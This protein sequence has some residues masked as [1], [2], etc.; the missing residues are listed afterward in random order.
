MHLHADLPLR[1]RPSPPPHPIPPLACVRVCAQPEKLGTADLVE[2]VE[3]GKG[4]VVKVTGIV[5]KGRTTSVLLR[6]SNK[7]VMEESER[8]LHDALCVIRCLVNKRFLITGGASPET[9]V[10]YQLSTWAKSLLG[11]ESYCVKAFAEALEV[12]PYTLAENAGLNPIQMVTELRNRHARGERTAGINVK[13]GAISD[14]AADNVL[15]P[16]LVTTSALTLA[17]ETVR[18]ILKID[19]IVPTR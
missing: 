1:R 11:M 12:V 19:D 6:G 17:T 9:E 13:K 18:M 16:L 14:M 7:L 4:R 3:C 15:Q 10:F 5:N 8:S 2:E